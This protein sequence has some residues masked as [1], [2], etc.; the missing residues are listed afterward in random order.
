MDSQEK[1]E[2]ALGLGYVYECKEYENEAHRLHDAAMRGRYRSGRRWTDFPDPSLSKI[3]E[4]EYYQFWQRLI[5]ARACLR[6]P[7]SITVIIDRPFCTE[8]AHAIRTCDRS[9]VVEKEITPERKT[10]LRRRFGW[11]G[12]TPEGYKPG[13]ACHFCKRTQ[14]DEPHPGLSLEQQHAVRAN[15][16]LKLGAMW[17]WYFGKKKKCCT[18]CLQI[19]FRRPRTDVEDAASGWKVQKK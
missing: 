12:S 8:C 4:T 11:L 2:I 17:T 6:C 15:A 9:C 5:S 18:D 13:D 3:T 19:R 14:L 7:N 1:T 16:H 10:A